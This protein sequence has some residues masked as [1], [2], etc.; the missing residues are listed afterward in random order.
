MTAIDTQLILCCL[1]LTRISLIINSRRRLKCVYCNRARCEIK[2][3][4]YYSVVYGLSLV[5][6][7][8]DVD[9]RVDRGRF[10]KLAFYW[11]SNLSKR[12][13]DTPINCRSQWLPFFSKFSL[14]RR[15]QRPKKRRRHA[16]R[17]SQSFQFPLDIAPLVLL[18]LLGFFP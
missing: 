14:Y 1:L 11:Y 5:P 7:R 8:T 18:L 10:D 17:R 9:R 2:K 15:C 3:S 12:P 13:I 16:T 4:S 6:M